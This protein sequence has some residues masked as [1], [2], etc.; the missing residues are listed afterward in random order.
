MVR[1]TPWADGKRM[2]RPAPS[3]S[4]QRAPPLSGD[5]SGTDVTRLPA[6][7]MTTVVTGGAGLPPSKDRTAPIS[8]TRNDMI[9]VETA[10]PAEPDQI[11]AKPPRT[12]QSNAPPFPTS[13]PCDPPANN[14][15]DVNNEVIARLLWLKTFKKRSAFRK[16]INSHCF[17]SRDSHQRK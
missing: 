14:A 4:P 10:N 1:V 7:S 11:A 2:H 16:K 6:V 12:F 3:A 8:L 13:L 15:T 17:R 5:R 9:P